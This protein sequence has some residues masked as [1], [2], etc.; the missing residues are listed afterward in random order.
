L[1]GLTKDEVE[2]GDV[3]RGMRHTRQQSVY[4]VHSFAEE[5]V[6]T[7]LFGGAGTLGRLTADEER[8]QIVRGNL[9]LASCPARGACAV[10]KKNLMVLVAVEVRRQPIVDLRDPRDRERGLVR[11][12]N[13]R[14]RFGLETCFEQAQGRPGETM[15]MGGE[16][17]HDT[18]SSGV[19]SA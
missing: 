1:A 10:P 18:D 13:V 16:R 7:Q 5:E 11:C 8:G 9:M 12:A 6:L 17:V 15:S 19:R 4:R 3:S 2:V 14:E